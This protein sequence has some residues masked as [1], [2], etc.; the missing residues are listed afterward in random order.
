[1]ADDPPVPQLKKRRSRT[2]VFISKLYDVVE[3]A[4]L[5]ATGTFDIAIIGVNEAALFATENIVLARCWLESPPT[6]LEIYCR[7]GK[8][9][10]QK[11]HI[12]KNQRFR[13]HRMLAT[14]E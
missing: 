4:T 2:A 10:K 12:A 5:R 3:R 9:R 1:M 14:G 8:R 13:A 11:N 6:M 7:D